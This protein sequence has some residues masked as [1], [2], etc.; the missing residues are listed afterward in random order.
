MPDHI[1]NVN[2]EVIAGKHKNDASNDRIRGEWGRTKKE[3]VRNKKDR[4]NKVVSTI[5]LKTY[6][7]KLKRWI[8][9]KLMSNLVVEFMTTNWLQWRVE[10]LKAPTRLEV[11]CLKMKMMKKIRISKVSSRPS[12][13]EMTKMAEAKGSKRKYENEQGDKNEDKI[14]ILGYRNWDFVC[15]AEGRLL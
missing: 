11:L 13:V 12:L 3:E 10:W 4:F 2:G 1:Q 5:K 14:G 15:R 6:G 8:I 9:W 7:I